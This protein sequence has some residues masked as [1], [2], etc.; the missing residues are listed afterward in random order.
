MVAGAAIGATRTTPSS[1]CPSPP[2]TTPLLTTAYSPSFRKNY[3]NEI[4]L[5][6]FKWERLRY[7]DDEIYIIKKIHVI[8]DW[9]KGLK[10]GT[11]KIEQEQLDHYVKQW[12]GLR[13]VNRHR[14]GLSFW[15]FLRLK[16]RLTYPLSLTRR[17]VSS[18]LL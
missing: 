4:I 11:H 15:G 2:R 9:L 10:V 5:D 7:L 12:Y 3:D 6:G 18:P 16:S 8:P 17:W 1:P 14:T 13:D